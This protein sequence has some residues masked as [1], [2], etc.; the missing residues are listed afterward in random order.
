ML[1]RG[2]GFAPQPSPGV[3]IADHDRFTTYYETE[4][5]GVAVL[6]WVT[7]RVV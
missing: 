4:L 1:V 3:A 7:A 6:H 2:F 5:T